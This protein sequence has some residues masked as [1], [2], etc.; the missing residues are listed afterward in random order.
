MKVRRDAD[1]LRAAK[2]IDRQ[3]VVVLSGKGGCGKTEV[4]GAVISYAISKINS[5]K[6]V[7]TVSSRCSECSI[8][9]EGSKVYISLKISNALSA[10]RQYFPQ[11]GF[12]GDT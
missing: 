11:N 8:G 10:C 3:P 5:E 12:S 2:L 1:Q 7:V 4:V 6:Y 9:K